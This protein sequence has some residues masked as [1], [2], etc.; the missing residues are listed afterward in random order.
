MIAYNPLAGGLLTASIA[1]GRAHRRHAVH[2]GQRRPRYQE[3]YWHD[4]E[5]ATVE[6]LQPLA[7]EAGVSLTRLA[8]AWVL[9]N[10]VITAPIVGASRPEQLDDVLR[11]WRRR[12]A[13]ISWARLDQLTR[14]Y[15]QGDDIR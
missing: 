1:G 2:A 6:T 13:P 4:R 11:R 5:F 14:E 7:K 9:A 8:V 15:R 3:R 12:S 10:P